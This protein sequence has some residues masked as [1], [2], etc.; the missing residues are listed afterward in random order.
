MKRLLITIDGSP[1]D[2]SSLTSA[3]TLTRRLG[4]HLSVVYT[5]PAPE[6]VYTY[7]EAAAP[8]IIDARDAEA[9]AASA[10]AAYETA[11][12]GWAGTD[13]STTDEP[14]AEVIAQLGPLTDLVIME[15]LSQ[16]EGPSA[17]GFNAALFDGA[18]PVFITPPAPRPTFAT[19]PVIAWNGSREAAEAVKS[20]VPL[21][22]LAG[23]ATVLTSDA[24]PAG[25]VHSLESYLR[26]YGVAMATEHFS[27]EQFTARGRARA[28]LKAVDDLS[29]D[30]LVMG[31]Y[32][33]NAVSALF[34]LGRATRKI[35]TAAQVPVL[36]HH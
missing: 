29:A 24:T 9:A 19:S 14:A 31:A 30:L 21:L 3:M 5:S 7:A 2:Q 8:L 20:A 25:S 17:S 28:L 6:V 13:W 10:R 23:R 1:N 16:E 12:A 18:G 11:C 27:A 32:G 35:V 4:A 22:Q 36:L 26:T 15:R 33:E 34:G